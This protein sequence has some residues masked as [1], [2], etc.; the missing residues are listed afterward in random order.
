MDRQVLKNLF[1]LI[2][3]VGHS[4]AGTFS[5][6]IGYLDQ[7]D[8]RVNNEVNPFPLGLSAVPLISYRSDNLMI[9]GP[10]VR[11]SLLRGPIGFALN[12]DAVGSRYQS[13]E[14]ELRST[15]INA[16]ASA[17]IFFLNFKHTADIGKTYNGNISI[18]SLA[19]RVQISEKVM[20]IPRLGY[21]FTNKAYNSYYYGVRS[22]EVGEY[23]EYEIDNARSQFIGVMTIIRLSESSSLSLNYGYKNL[24]QEIFQSPT[25]SLKGYRNW[26]VF[27]SFPL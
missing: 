7:E 6:G 8:F 27:F 20:M 13:E 10:R 25:V 5:T 15:A 21:E 1:F 23:N 11:Y 24:D 16:G 12:L 26:G 9:N 22:N 3:F 14:V 18:V 17:R 2:F 4:Y 19:H